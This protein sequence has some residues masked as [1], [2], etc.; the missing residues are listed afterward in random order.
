MDDRRRLLA[1][2]GALAL[3][4]GIRWLWGKKD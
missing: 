4:A 3:I 2:A 1:G